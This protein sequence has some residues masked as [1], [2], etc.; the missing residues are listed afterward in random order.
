M[1]MTMAGMRAIKRETWDQWLPR[2][3]NVEGDVWQVVGFKRQ[4]CLD[5]ERRQGAADNS[6]GEPQVR[7]GLLDRVLGALVS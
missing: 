7:H 6:H 4:A 5:P 2:G 1:I 3:M